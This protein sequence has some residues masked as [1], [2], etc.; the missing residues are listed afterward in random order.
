M[1]VADFDNWFNRKFKWGS[2]LR[3]VNKIPLIAHIRFGARL[4]YP[5]AISDGRQHGLGHSAYCATSPNHCFDSLASS[6]VL[7]PF[8]V[9]RSSICRLLR[10]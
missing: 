9:C 5:S 6:L 8:S 1:K 4:Y 3:S 2:E 10:G 7:L